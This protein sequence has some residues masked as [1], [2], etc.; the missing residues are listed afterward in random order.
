[1][2]HVTISDVLRDSLPFVQFEKH[3]KHPW[4]SVIFGNTPPWVFFKFFKLYKLYQI[5]K[6]YHIKISITVFIVVSCV[7]K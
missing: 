6:H 7:I 1:M 4:K 3:E 5:A 2:L